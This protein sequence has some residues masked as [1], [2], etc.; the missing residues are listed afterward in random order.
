M[1]VFLISGIIAKVAQGRVWTGKQAL[2]RG[3]VDEIGGLWRALNVAAQLANDSRAFPSFNV[4]YLHGDDAL[5]TNLTEVKYINVQTLREARSGFPLPFTGGSKISLG[6]VESVSWL[7]DDTIFG[8]GLA[9]VESTLGAKV[10]DTLTTLGISA[11]LVY[12]VAGVSGVRYLTAMSE[13]LDNWNS[14]A[15]NFKFNILKNL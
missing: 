5:V 1:Q 3:L 12:A 7:C 13:L 14:N 6:E 8:S 9:T 10:P 2:D 15:E 4:S 11:E